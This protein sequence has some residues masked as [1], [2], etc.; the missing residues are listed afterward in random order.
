[1]INS[2]LSALMPWVSLPPEIACNLD[3]FA[4][5]QNCGRETGLSGSGV[6]PLK[7]LRLSRTAEFFIRACMTKA[8][9]YVMRDAGR[10]GALRSGQ[11]VAAF[12]A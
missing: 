5:H 3:R 7:C 11:V 1:M 6:R 9:L 2:D 10:A 8:D 4:S 12:D